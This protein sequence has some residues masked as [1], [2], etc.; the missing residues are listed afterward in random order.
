VRAASKAVAQFGS[1]QKLSELVL[2][3]VDTKEEK[4][5]LTCWRGV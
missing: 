4:L 3:Y 5:G 1:S 2:A